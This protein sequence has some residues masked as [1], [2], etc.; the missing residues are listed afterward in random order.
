MNKYRKLLMRMLPTIATALF[1]TGC[2]SELPR[3][4][5]PLEYIDDAEVVDMPGIRVWG[6]EKSALFYDDI[7]L[8]IKNEKEG[9]FPRGPDGELNYAGL[10][11][12]GG[13][14]HGAFGAG[15]LK[16]WSKS[17]TRPVFKI[18][19]GMSTGALIAPFALL[20]SDYDEIIETAFTTVSADDIF[21]MRFIWRLPAI[22]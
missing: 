8:S 5:V 7:V 18:V 19:T 12:S 3:N 11:L 15:Y 14:D 1:L 9:L 20:G 13:G 6:D 21:K 10:S 22:G 16:G 2:A 4:A 17:G